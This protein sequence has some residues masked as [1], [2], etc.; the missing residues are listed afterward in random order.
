MA[1]GGASLPEAADGTVYDRLEGL[2]K[3][4]GGLI[5]IDAEGNIELPFNSM[6]MYRGWID[7]AGA[8]GV[9]ITRGESVT[10][11]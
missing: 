4:L 6:G 11:F 2:R 9:G 3:G 10:R 1:Y 5:A 8:G 7:A